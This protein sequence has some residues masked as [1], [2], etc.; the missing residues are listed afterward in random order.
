MRAMCLCRKPHG[1]WVPYS[2]AVVLIGDYFYKL[3]TLLWWNINYGYS[4]RETEREKKVLLVTTENV[5][6]NICSSFTCT[7]PE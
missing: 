6:T 1:V 7:K 2:H 3:M 4:F 5:N